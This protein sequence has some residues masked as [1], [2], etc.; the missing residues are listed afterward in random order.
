MKPMQLSAGKSVFRSF[1]VIPL[2]ASTLALP[3]SALAREETPEPASTSIRS[4]RRV[5]I[6]AEAG[7]N[8]LSGVGMQVSYHFMPQLS[9]DVAGGLSALGWKAGARAR[10]NFV[11]SNFTPFLGAGLMIGSG[12]GDE[13]LSVD[14]GTRTVLA[15]V[16]LA[17][18]AQVVGG[19]EYVADGGFSIMATAGYAFAL[20]QNPE[21]VSGTPT[22]A[23][24][25]VFELLYGNGI[26]LGLA[27]GYTF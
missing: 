25:Q 18:F 3:S 5:G 19:L 24:R 4:Q 27:L 7:W 14:D 11:T 13:P 6:M 23:H 8:S 9:L 15:R 10:Y 20:T 16:G 21:V 12:A 2:L 17:P 26:S 1:A 22:E